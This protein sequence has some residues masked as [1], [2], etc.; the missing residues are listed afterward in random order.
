MRFLKN[1]SAIKILLKYQCLGEFSRRTFCIDARSVYNELYEKDRSNLVF[2]GN[3]V[4]ESKNTL[5]VL[6]N[7]KME[8]NGPRVEKL[9]TSP[10]KELL[11]DMITFPHS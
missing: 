6:G 9:K 3:R 10:V 7:I 4:Q 1:Y 11:Q 2:A 8:Y 5:S